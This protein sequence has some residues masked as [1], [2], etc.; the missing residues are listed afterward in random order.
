[1][2]SVPSM[3]DGSTGIR[4]TGAVYTP[5]EVAAA[6]VAHV[7]TLVPKVSPHVLEPS[8]GDGAF[9]RNL[10]R[11]WASGRYTLVDVDRNVIAR[12]RRVEAK[13]GSGEYAS[14]HAQDFLKFAFPLIRDGHRPFDLVIGN[15]PFIRSRNFAASL[16]V[17][18]AA[19][20]KVSGYPLKD[21][22]NSWAAFLTASAELVTEAGVLAF[23]LPYELVTV[24]Y[25]QE[26]LRRVS[27]QFRRVDIYVSKTKAFPQIDQDAIVL[28]AQ[29]G[30]SSEAGLFLSEVSSLAELSSQSARQLDL[31]E[32]ADQPLELNGFLFEDE[33]LGLLKRL[34]QSNP[35]LETY[36][37]SS[38]GIVSAANEFFILSRSEVERLGFMDIALPILKKGSFA[39]HRPEFTDADFQAVAEADPSYLLKI[40]GEKAELSKEMKAYL[41]EGEEAGYHRRYKCQK[42]LRW[43]EVPIIER[44]ESFVFKRAHSFPR[45]C[46]NRANVYLTDTAYGLKIKEGATA[47]GLCFSFYNSMTLLFA[48]TDGRFYGGGVLELSPREFR[49]LPIAYHEPTDAEYEAFVS[50]HVKAKGRPE[51]ILDFGDA[52]LGPKLGLSSEELLRLRQAWSAVRAHRM[53][54]SGRSP[55]R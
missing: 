7:S 12:L 45:M 3:A 23:V 20:A 50:A 37:G 25:G 34:R 31:S 18:V 42:R 40:R 26:A 29:K 48:E 47:R 16:K 5:D 54:H 15:P 35:R 11:H 32:A 36:A 30:G 49:G 17:S 52:W 28:V 14:L 46:L 27:R 21:L 8:V 10:R 1:M 53:R 2:N 19:L 22:K 39:S 33:T 4:F 44:E 24:A 38:P 13:G 6:L 41:L 51:P 43:Y 9:L 55:T